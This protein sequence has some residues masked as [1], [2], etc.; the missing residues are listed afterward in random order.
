MGK[1]WR[2][3]TDEEKRYALHRSR[4]D[5]INTPKGWLAPG[6]GEIYH[7]H[8]DFFS[9]GQKRALRKMLRKRLNAAQKACKG[10]VGAMYWYGEGWYFTPDEWAAHPTHRGDSHFRFWL[11][12]E[13]EL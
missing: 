1:Q 3:M 4:V 12:R 9:E 7:H 11:S 8:G 6:E 10:M 2:T 13:G 5:C